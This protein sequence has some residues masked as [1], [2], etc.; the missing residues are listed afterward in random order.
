VTPAPAIVRLH[1]ENG[2][3]VLLLERIQCS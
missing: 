3:L 1:G 2:F